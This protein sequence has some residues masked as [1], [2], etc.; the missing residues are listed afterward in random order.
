[1]NRLN[2]KTIASQKNLKKITCL[3]A[4]TSSIAKIIDKHVD[5]ILIGD[6]VGTVIYGME[7]TQHVTLDMM[8]AHGKAV[9][10]SSKRAFTLIDMPYRT[11]TNNKEALSNARKLL[12]F[13]NCQS[14]KLEA[15][16]NNR[17]IIRHLVKNKVK[18]VSHIGVTP[19]DY[20]NFN[21]I[22][23][24]GNTIGERGKILNLAIDLEKA[25]SSMIVLECMKENL[26]KEISKKLKIPTIGIGAS[27]ECDGQVLVT[28]DI[29][30]TQGLIAKPKFV[31]S[32]VKLND[33]IEKAVKKYC[34]EVINKKFPKKNNTYL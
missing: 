7:N 22:R 34:L 27:L 10:N 32:Y 24:V 21:K 15:N 25:G 11:Y 14:V 18:V 28:N 30:E 16:N 17:S 3:T 26:A 13:T 12:R 1:M 19:Q 29:L 33:V 23:S 8:M 4:Y 2:L 20:K 31:K 6:S 5:I 9:V